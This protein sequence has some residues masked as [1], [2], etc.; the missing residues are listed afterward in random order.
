MNISQILKEE[1]V[2]AKPDKEE[3]KILKKDADEAVSLLELE[4]KKQEINADVFIG[5]SFARGTLLKREDYDI[6]IF[7]RFDWRLENI[8]LFLEK[9]VNKVV[10]KIKKR[11][12]KLHGSRDYFRIYNGKAMMEI[13]PVYK[14]KK[15]REAR[16]VT[17]LSYFHVS[18][19]KRKLRG[20]LAQEVL[21]AKQFC[22]AQKVYGAESY[23]Q[24]FSGY[25][26]ECL[27]IYYKSFEKMLRALIKVVDR[28]VIDIEKHYK[29][30][31][32]VLFSLNEG[33]LQSPIILVDPT[34]KERNVLAALSRETFVKFQERARAFL[35]K[36]SL[37]FF[38]VKEKDVEDLKKL[39]RKKKAEFLQIILSTDK[40]AGDIAGTKMRKFSRYLEFELRRYFNIL[41]REFSYHE[42]QR[43]DFYIV[44]QPKKKIAVLGPPKGMKSH[45]L[46]FKK[47]HKKTFEGA[48]YLHAEKKIDFSTREFLEKFSREEQRKL[49]E[50]GI[51]G[52]KVLEEKKNEGC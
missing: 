7:V 23:I 31:Q 37:S 9:I 51:I 47:K 18:Y 32:E 50:M 1:R 10:E 6:D 36:P 14:I 39:A 12:E 41:T 38:E 45:V 29:N 28:I 19:V 15:P 5:G 40:Q 17:D 8:S 25:A 22:H 13:I 48:G 43:A 30:K 4:I 21:L 49:R 34:G 42:G 20:D 24:G 27:I 33:R 52:M 46:A 11:A 3:L 16:N 35:K 2:R 26:L 44:V